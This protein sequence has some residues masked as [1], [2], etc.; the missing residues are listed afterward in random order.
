ML[1]EATMN[2]EYLGG[3]L[4]Y[5]FESR[6]CYGLILIGLRNRMLANLT[7]A[8][9]AETVL[10]EI[11]GLTYELNDAGFDVSVAG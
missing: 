6:N 3:T 5:S 10:D 9:R 4:R 1:T 8:N 11:N 7:P 2:C